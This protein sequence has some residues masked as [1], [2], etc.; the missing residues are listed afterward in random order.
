MTMVFTP[1]LTSDLWVSVL[2]GRCRRG[3]LFGSPHLTL[4]RGGLG[5]AFFPAPAVL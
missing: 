4:L 2:A 3:R 5:R 1:A